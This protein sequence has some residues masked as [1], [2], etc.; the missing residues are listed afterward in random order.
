VSAPAN[1]EGLELVGLFTL[2]LLGIAIVALAGVGI[3]CLSD[4]HT[5]RLAPPPCPACSEAK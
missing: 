2:I 1:N 3:N 4:D 5:A